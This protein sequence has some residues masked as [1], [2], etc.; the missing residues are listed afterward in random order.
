ML[1]VLE[2]TLPQSYL[3]N[4]RL[5]VDIQPDLPEIGVDTRRLQRVLTSMVSNAIKY[6]PNGGSIRAAV[7]GENDSI[8]FTVTDNGDWIPQADLERVFEP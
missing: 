4:Q 1:A 5:E 3:K 2:I 7:A 6:T 8:K